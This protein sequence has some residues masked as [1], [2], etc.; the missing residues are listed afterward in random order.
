[1]DLSV[2][3]WIASMAWFMMNSRTSYI[4]SEINRINT[5]FCSL[6]KIFVTWFIIPDMITDGMMLNWGYLLFYHIR[7]CSQ[8]KWKCLLIAHSA[9]I[10]SIIKGMGCKITMVSSHNRSD[11][12]CTI[13]WK[14]RSPEYRIK[15]RI[16]RMKANIA[17][18]KNR[19]IEGRWSAW[20]THDRLWID[21]WLIKWYSRI[22]Q[23]YHTIGRHD[24]DSK[25]PETDIIEHHYIN[26]DEK[27][28]HTHR[29]EERMNTK[30]V[31]FIEKNREKYTKKYPRC[32]RLDQFKR[33]KPNNTHYLLDRNDSSE[34][35][36]F[37]S[38]DA[39]HIFWL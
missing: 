21:V 33:M 22:S 32:Y 4:F 27:H 39:I 35:E 16:R 17:P 36:R 28:I 20:D 5:K 14:D 13:I 34:Q 37:K 2:I 30:W 31:V 26:S 3:W 18:K 38:R 8:K 12:E 19:I 9:R 11:G 24:P 1:M 23:V 29:S 15:I 25:I 7:E 10:C 6:D